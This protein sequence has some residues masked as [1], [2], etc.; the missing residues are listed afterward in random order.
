[1]A[2]VGTPSQQDDSYTTLQAEEAGA[3]AGAGVTA[4][5]NEEH[6]KVAV[7]TAPQIEKK[8]ETTHLLDPPDV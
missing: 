5:E 3:G 1:M 7:G 4:S 2:V 6:E 8:N